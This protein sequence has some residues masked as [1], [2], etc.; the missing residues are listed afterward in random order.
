MQHGKMLV[1]L[2]LAQNHT[3]GVMMPEDDV[4]AVLGSG[5]LLKKAKLGH[6][7]TG[8]TG[9]TAASAT[10]KRAAHEAE[11]RRASKVLL[12]AEKFDTIV[13]G[14]KPGQLRALLIENLRGKELGS[15]WHTCAALRTAKAALGGDGNHT[16]VLEEG[17]VLGEGS[18]GIVKEARN[19]SFAGEYALKMLKEVRF[20][21]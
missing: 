16:G 21:V 3:E 10:E 9:E 5:A 1:P 19:S 11:V 8:V 2:L 4:Q 15:L 18:F 20:A 12:E 6:V 7:G 17:T 13:K 14:R